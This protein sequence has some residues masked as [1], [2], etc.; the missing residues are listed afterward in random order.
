MKPVPF[1]WGGEGILGPPVV[2]FYPFL[3]GGSPTQIDYR[4]KG[5][6]IVTSLLEDLELASE[7]DAKLGFAMPF[8]DW[9]SEACRSNFRLASTVQS[10]F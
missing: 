6:F 8:G 4:K 5:T 2:P 7:P 3:G 1:L 9:A 10:L